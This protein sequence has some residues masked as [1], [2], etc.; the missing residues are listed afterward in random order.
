MASFKSFKV[1][2]YREKY[3]LYEDDI[4]SVTVTILDPLYKKAEWLDSRS[5]RNRLYKTV[6]D[7][8]EDKLNEFGINMDN[9]A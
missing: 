7:N 1:E 5:T 8:I 3:E 2:F 6:A 4:S 9:Q